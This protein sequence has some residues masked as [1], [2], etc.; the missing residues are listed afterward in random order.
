MDIKEFL[1]R[2]SSK[3]VNI[4]AH[5]NYGEEDEHNSI[6]DGNLDWKDLLNKLKGSN[7]KKIVIENDD[8]DDVIKSKKALEK[9]YKIK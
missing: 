5:N 6:E 2:V 7:L 8:K 1:D 3:L 9:F 4:H